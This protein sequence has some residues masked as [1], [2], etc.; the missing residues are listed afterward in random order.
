[1][2]SSN[3]FQEIEKDKM[4]DGQWR[5]EKTGMGMRRRLQGRGRKHRLLV[6]SE[7]RSSHPFACLQLKRFRIMLFP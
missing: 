7:P 4:T 5:Q 3:G 2:L 6:H 1:M